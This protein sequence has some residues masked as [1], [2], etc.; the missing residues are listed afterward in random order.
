MLY[1]DRD[2]RPGVKF[3]DMDLIGLPRQ[4]I[5]GPRGW[6]NRLVEVK[7]RN[8]DTRIET[9]VDAALDPLLKLAS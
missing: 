2:E 3:A 8:A 7:N 6:S 9:S 1:D 5:V 4:V